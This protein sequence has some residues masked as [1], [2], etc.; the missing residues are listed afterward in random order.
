MVDRGFGQWRPVN[1]GFHP[2]QLEK[3]QRDRG[4]VFLQIRR[5]FRFGGR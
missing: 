2:V 5:N 3:Y 4:S 1:W